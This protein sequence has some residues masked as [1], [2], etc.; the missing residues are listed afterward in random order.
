MSP[1]SVVIEM[2]ILDLNADSRAAAK[3]LWQEVDELQLE[4]DARKRLATHG[5]RSGVIGVHVPQW[6]CQGLSDQSKH[7]QMD[8]NNGMAVPSDIIVQRRL[9]CRAGRRREVPIGAHFEKLTVTDDS[10]SPTEYSS[11]QCLLTLTTSPLG[12]GRVK[13]E[14]VPEIHYGEPKQR[15]VGQGGHFRSDIALESASFDDMKVTVTLNP[16]ETLVFAATPKE[17]RLGR[18]VCQSE[19]VE[20]PPGRLV[21]LRL[22]QTQTD[23]LF[24]PQQSLTPIT[25][26]LD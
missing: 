11:G 17:D 13:L 23:D 9:Q 10:D 20:T 18:V 15:W 6:I 16:G 3:Q 5:L 1:D 26:L 12:D 24:A 4:P 2:A 19:A 22:A 25:T 8:S 14:L 7:L 21:L